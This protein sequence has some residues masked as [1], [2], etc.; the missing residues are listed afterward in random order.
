MD[1][2]SKKITLVFA[3][4]VGSISG[5]VAGGIGDSFFDGMV[6]GAVSGA[7]IATFFL[8]KPRGFGD[9]SIAIEAFS[10]AGLAGAIVASVTTNAG[11]IGAFI[12]S[13]VGWTLGLFLPAILI[14][15]FLNDEK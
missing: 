8:Y 11:W 14:S 2:S 4:I 9:P 7:V 10:P 6:A 13:A 5:A 15:I 12:G 1:K 3:A